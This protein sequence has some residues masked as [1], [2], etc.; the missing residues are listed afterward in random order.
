MD[1][2]DLVDLIFGL[3]ELSLDLSDLRRNRNGEGRFKRPSSR[4]VV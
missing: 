2:T 1:L 4:Y 3:I